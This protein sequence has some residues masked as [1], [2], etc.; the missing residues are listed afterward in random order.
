MLH[1]DRKM[2]IQENKRGETIWFAMC[3]M[4]SNAILLAFANH[5]ENNPCF[6]PVQTVVRRQGRGSLLPCFSTHRACHSLSSDEIESL[7]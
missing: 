3:A 4:N 5:A 2:L 1:G 7:S 6:F